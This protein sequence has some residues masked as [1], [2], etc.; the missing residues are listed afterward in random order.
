M[1]A[2]L[3]EKL[4]K[5]TAR[6]L[7]IEKLF[8]GGA[9]DKGLLKEWDAL[10][11]LIAYH[12]KARIENTDIG[13]GVTVRLWSDA[14]AY[15]VIGKTAKTITIQRDNAV[16][17]GFKPDFTPGGFVGHVHNQHEQGKYYVYTPNPDGE[18][19]KIHAGKD[20]VFREYHGGKAL[21]TGRHEFYDYNF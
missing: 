11:T 15:T 10:G 7:E 2:E 6:R 12:Q 8:L 19:R 21:A 18:T 3:K 13:D 17:S 1:N 14:H 5:A 9:H 4:E 20:G 16:L